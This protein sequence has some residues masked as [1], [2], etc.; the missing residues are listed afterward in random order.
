MPEYEKLVYRTIQELL[1]DDNLSADCQQYLKLIS[2]SRIVSRFIELGYS[3]DFALSVFTTR[4]EFIT[5]KIKKNKPFRCF[6][7]TVLNRRT[8]Q[9]ST[10]SLSDYSTFP[11]EPLVDRTR[12]S[13]KL[14]EFN[15]CVSLVVTELLEVLLRH[16]QESENFLSVSKAT[17]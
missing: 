9:L 8:A 17:T 10:G 6:I 14:E 2:E 5:I 3:I 15:Q 16:I 13:I 12:K 11:P 1:D 7:I 4:S